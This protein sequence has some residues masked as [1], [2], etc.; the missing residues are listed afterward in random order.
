M[1]QRFVF[2]F[3]LF[4]QDKLSVLA[5]GGWLSSALAAL[6]TRSS[7]RIGAGR[8]H[9]GIVVLGRLCHCNHLDTGLSWPLLLL[10]VKCFVAVDVCGQKRC[11]LFAV[12]LL[13]GVLA[14]QHSAGVLG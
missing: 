14:D 6:L 11:F 2:V 4:A 12:D 3:E 10:L 8:F 7:Q 1:D 5:L 13:F 9:R